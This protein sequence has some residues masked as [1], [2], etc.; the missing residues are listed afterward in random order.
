V[1]DLLKHFEPEIESLTLIPSD[2]G[3]YEVTVNDKL[4]YSKLATGRH[5]EPN[6]VLHLVDKFLKEGKK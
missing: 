2:G 1:A 4:I 6:E 5:A 3:R